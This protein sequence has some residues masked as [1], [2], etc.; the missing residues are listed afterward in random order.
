MY[1]LNEPTAR[2]TLRNR[3]FSVGC[4]GSLRLRDPRGCVGLRDHSACR[5]GQDTGPSES[6][7]ENDRGYQMHL[8]GNCLAPLSLRLSAQKLL[9]LFVILLVA[10]SVSF[11]LKHRAA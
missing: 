8:C 6:A 7:A 3:R 1:F 10:I 9:M 2:L 4:P 11:E 5:R